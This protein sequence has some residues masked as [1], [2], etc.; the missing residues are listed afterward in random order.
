MGIESFG[1]LKREWAAERTATA[2]SLGITEQQASEILEALPF[3]AIPS[4][5]DVVEIV[6][7]VREVDQV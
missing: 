7:S 5:V 6:R 1:A 2:E 3:S 4:W